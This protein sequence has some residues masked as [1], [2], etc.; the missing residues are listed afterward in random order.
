MMIDE[1]VI[2]SNRNNRIHYIYIYIFKSRVSFQ[3]KT[4]YY[5]RYEQ[6]RKRELK[7]VWII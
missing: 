3:S 7:E 2:D 5:Q 4:G 6:K 1:V